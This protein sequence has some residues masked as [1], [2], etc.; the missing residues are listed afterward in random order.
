MAKRRK[1]RKQKILHNSR[2]SR[3]VIL[4]SDKT[5]EIP[6]IQEILP[7]PMEPKRPATGSSIISTA[8]YQYLPKDLM[9]TAS[10]TGAIVL[11]ELLLFLLAKR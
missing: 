10:L 7:Q 3:P 9:K 1:T 8:L 6:T 4:T 11:A 2:Q 5:P